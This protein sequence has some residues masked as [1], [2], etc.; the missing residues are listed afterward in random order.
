MGMGRYAHPNYL[1][2]L[3]STLNYFDSWDGKYFKFLKANQWLPP[4]IL[5]VAVNIAFTYGS[6]SLLHAQI[7]LHKYKSSMLSTLQEYHKV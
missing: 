4:G 2:D 3:F 1:V 5:R 7:V 6:S